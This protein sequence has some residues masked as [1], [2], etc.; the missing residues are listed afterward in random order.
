MAKLPERSADKMKQ[1]MMKTYL[2][3]LY[4]IYRLRR[5]F[6]LLKGNFDV[7][8]APP[9]VLRDNEK[10][11]VDPMQQV[12]IGYSSEY[13]SERTLC[14]STPWLAVD[15]PTIMD[16]QIGRNVSPLFA[17]D[18]H[19]EK[20]DRHM[21]HLLI[22][23]PDSPELHRLITEFLN[24]VDSEPDLDEAQG[25]PEP[26][27][28]SLV[29]MISE[30]NLSERLL[31][32][33]TQVLA[34]EETPLMQTNILLFW[35]NLQ[36][37]EIDHQPVEKRL[38]FSDDLLYIS[39]T[40]RYDQILAKLSELVTAMELGKM[41]PA[42]SSTLQLWATVYSRQLEREELMSEQEIYICRRMAW[43]QPDL[44]SPKALDVLARFKF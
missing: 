29:D 15:D 4:Q 28:G 43:K 41:D 30:Q 21:T 16:G 23:T 3:F 35:L 17:Y 6:L 26:Q 36:T 34:G 38:E 10:T 22:H 8:Q 31:E 2:S 13:E 11:P 14:L 33:L 5:G 42:K 32:Q 19:D 7:R 44:F 25:T 37:D 1:L 39:P 9:K 27:L 40:D 12:D 20:G 24:F 18:V